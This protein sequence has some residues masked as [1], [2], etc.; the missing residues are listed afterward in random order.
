M[1][2]VQGS[3][4][5]YTWKN[6]GTWHNVGTPYRGWTLLVNALC[7]SLSIHLESMFHFHTWLQHKSM[8]TSLHLSSS[9]PHVPAIR[10]IPLRR[11]TKRG[12]FSFP[13]S[14]C[15]WYMLHRK[16]MMTSSLYNTYHFKLE[17]CRTKL[18]HLLQISM[19]NKNS[20]NIMV[21][22]NNFISLVKKGWY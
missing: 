8:G 10:L 7:W 6:G 13:L 20:K 16:K 3:V 11:I 2:I 9:R 12:Q 4:D 15:V 17:W 21:F 22:F 1:I 18:K 19:I 14:R 5:D